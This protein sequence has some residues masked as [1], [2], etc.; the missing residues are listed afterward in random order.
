MLFDSVSKRYSECGLR[1]G[2]ITKN[3]QVRKTVMKFCIARL[4]PPLIGQIM[5]EA[6]LDA[7]EDYMR[8]T[9][10]EYVE[11]RNTLIDGLNR[12]EGVYAPIPMGAF[13]TL[14][15]L[16]IDDSDKFCEWCLKDFRHNGAT[17]MLAPGIGFYSDEKLGKQLVRIAFSLPKEELQTSL[18]ILKEALKA[19]NNERNKI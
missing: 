15:K 6:S 13:Y 12:I 3:E 1:V 16:P 7:S 5:A 2:V 14:A 9:Y 4:S 19:Y 17:I 18:E 10:N 8:S 11:R